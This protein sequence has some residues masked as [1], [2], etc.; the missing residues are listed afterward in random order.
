M[1]TVTQRMLHSEK[2]K[3]FIQHNKQAELHDVVNFMEKLKLTGV[4]DYEGSES[5]LG[6]GGKTS[7]L[8]RCKVLIERC[9]FN[10]EN[11]VLDHLR[12]TLPAEWES[13]LN[14][15][16]NKLTISLSNGIEEEI[17]EIYDEEDVA[18]M[19]LRRLED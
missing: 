4:I 16:E 6:V 12:K 2:L 9:E 14:Y 7:T 17:A 19:L 10:E 5:Q 8:L 3:L 11:E 13:I 15:L 1:V 18:D